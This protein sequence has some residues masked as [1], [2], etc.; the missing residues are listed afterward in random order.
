MIRIYPN[1]PFL[2]IFMNKEPKHKTIPAPRVLSDDPWFGP[3]VI[4][5]ANRIYLAQKEEE[6][7]ILT[8]ENGEPDNIHELM[9]NISV[10][11]ITSVSDMS[12][13]NWNSGG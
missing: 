13:R 8:K 6:K 1:Y 7:N 5:D 10:K 3:A 12:G 11:S 9:Y 2:P 4:S